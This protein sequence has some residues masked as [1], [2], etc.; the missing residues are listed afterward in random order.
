MYSIYFD[1]IR[2]LHENISSGI[3][4]SKTKNSRK[5]AF[6]VKNT[7]S[8][9]VEDTQKAI[10]FEQ[11]SQNNACKHLWHFI[12]TSVCRSADATG[13][14][15][16]YAR[17]VDEFVISTVLY[18]LAERYSY[19]RPGGSIPQC[20]CACVRRHSGSKSRSLL[21]TSLQSVSVYNHSPIF[22]RNIRFFHFYLRGT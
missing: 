22:I 3:S 9:R 20:K 11:N 16:L 5:E 13:Q 19:F 2:I 10:P 21:F 7:L 4:P 12:T 14:K 17:V 15:V 8:Q 18:S 6:W 1:I